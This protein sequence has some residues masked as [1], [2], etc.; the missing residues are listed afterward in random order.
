M[1]LSIPQ[2]VLV[3]WPW[4]SHLTSLN[5]GFPSCKVGAALGM[6]R[7]EHGGGSNSSCMSLAHG[8]LSALLGLLTPLSLIP[9]EIT[10]P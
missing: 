3:L 6:V 5:F 9:L 1:W 10:G 7:T 8:W 4:A 2:T